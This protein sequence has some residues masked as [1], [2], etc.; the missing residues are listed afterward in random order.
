MAEYEGY[1]CDAGGKIL[2][3]QC[4]VGRHKACPDHREPEPEDDNAGPLDG[5]HCDCGCHS[6]SA[7]KEG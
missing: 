4:Y 7:S 5:H 6:Q 1:V 2:S 3:L